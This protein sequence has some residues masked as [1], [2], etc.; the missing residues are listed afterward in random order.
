MQTATAQ[1]ENSVVTDVRCQH[2]GRIIAQK[3]IRSPLDNHMQPGLS[4]LLRCPCG[5]LN[6]IA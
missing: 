2:C 4:F 3:V 1:Q 6:I 5:H